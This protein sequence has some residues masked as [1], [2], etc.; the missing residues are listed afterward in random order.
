MAFDITFRYAGGEKFHVCMPSSLVQ[1][2]TD[3]YGLNFGDCLSFGPEGNE[4][5]MIGAPSTP[6]TS[7]Y[8]RPRVSRGIERAE[9][10]LEKVKADP[11]YP[12]EEERMAQLLGG[13]RRMKGDRKARVEI[14]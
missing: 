5:E 7:G 6:D 11:T 10:L 9:R 3:K 14:G 2:Q 12:W 4:T 8:Y 1:A 13:L